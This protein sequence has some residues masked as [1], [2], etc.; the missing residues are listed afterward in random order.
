MTD[1]QKI[2]DI[3]QR[4]KNTLFIL[5]GFP[6][7]GKSF[8]VNQVKSQTEI[9]VVSIDDIFK[10]KGFDWNTHVLPTTDE[11][12]QIFDESYRVTKES[13]QQGKNVMYDSTNQTVLSRDTLRTLARLVGATTYVLYIKTPIDKVWKR[14][15]ANKNNPIRSVV[16]KELVQQTI[17]MFQEPTEIE[18]VIVVDN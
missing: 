15:E 10:T 3:I 6:Y 13:L 16:S 5:S 4:S 14:W 11:W 7:A 18:N 17:D 2:I 9:V 8:I 1:L 12:E